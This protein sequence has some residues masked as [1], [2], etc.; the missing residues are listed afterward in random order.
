MLC[1]PVLHGKLGLKCPCFTKNNSTYGN[2]QAPE[3][4]VGNVVTLSQVLSPR[5]KELLK[6]KIVEV[7]FEDDPFV[8]DWKGWK[9][10]VWNVS[11]FYGTSPLVISGEKISGF[12]LSNSFVGRVPQI[13]SDNRGLVVT[14]ARGSKLIMTFQD[15]LY[16]IQF[17]VMALRDKMTVTVDDVD[18]PPKSF[19]FGRNVKNTKND[20]IG[21]K[22]VPDYEGSADLLFKFPSVKKVEITFNNRLVLSDILF[23]K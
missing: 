19:M 15:D 3:K 6:P 4:D 20:F 18:L 8:Q 13:V 17:S 11:N 21:G 16:H 10:H 23:K 5:D 1:N 2:S 14:G 12:N 9:R 22:D 7:P